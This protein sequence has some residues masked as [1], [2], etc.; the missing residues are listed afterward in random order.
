VDGPDLATVKD[1]HRF[2]IATSRGKIGDEGKPTIDSINAFAEH[3]F[4]GFARVAG[5]PIDEKDSSSVYCLA[6]ESACA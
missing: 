3:F 2:C 5:T 1:F 6:T 4:T